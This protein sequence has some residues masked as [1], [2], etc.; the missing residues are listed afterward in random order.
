MSFPGRGL[1][2]GSVKV[3]ADVF[4]GLAPDGDQPLLIAFS[5]Y[6]QVFFPEADIADLKIHEF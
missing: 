1:V 5:G 6:Q 4:C 3:N 2:P